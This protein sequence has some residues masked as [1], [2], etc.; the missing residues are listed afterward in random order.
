MCGG[1]AYGKSLYLP[2]NFAVNLKLFQKKIVLSE[3]KNYYSST[4]KLYLLESSLFQNKFYFLT[5]LKKYKLNNYIFYVVRKQDIFPA[6][7]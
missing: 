4:I 2:H 1:R 6:L 7:S 5:S 3:G